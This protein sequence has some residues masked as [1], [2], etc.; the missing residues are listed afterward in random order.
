MLASMTTRAE[1]EYVGVASP[2]EGGEPFPPVRVSLE[3]PAGGIVRAD[4]GNRYGNSALTFLLEEEKIGAEGYLGSL[5]VLPTPLTELSVKELK[6]ARPLVVALAEVSRDVRERSISPDE[7]SFNS[8]ST[9]GCLQHDYL[10]NS[11]VK[12]NVT[13]FDVRLDEPLE[14]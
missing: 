5:S 11:H 14:R 8:R 3:V 2:L 7:L 13:R 6:A 4:L 1:I 9:T 10:V 12:M